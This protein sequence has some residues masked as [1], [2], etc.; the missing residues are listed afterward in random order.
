MVVVVAMVAVK[1]VVVVRRSRSI[2]RRSGIGSG[3]TSK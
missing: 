1:M 3:A 2:R